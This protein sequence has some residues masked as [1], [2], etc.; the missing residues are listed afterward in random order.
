M[1]WLTLPTLGKRDSLDGTVPSEEPPEKRAARTP[2]H[3]RRLLA[4]RL[5][6]TDDQLR[7]KAMQRLRDLVLVVP[8]QS[9]L[10]RALLDFS[11]NLLGKIGFHVFLQMLLGSVQHRHSSKDPWTFTNW[12]FG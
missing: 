1:P 10:G 7:A 5:A 2:F 8:E 6:Q 11:G 3:C 4:T 12:P 9:K